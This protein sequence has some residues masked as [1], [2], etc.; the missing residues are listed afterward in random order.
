MYVTGIK[1]YLSKDGKKRIKVFLGEE[2]P[3]GGIEPIGVGTVLDTLPIPDGSYPK[4]CEISI[5]QYNGSFYPVILSI[6]NL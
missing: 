4:G 5:R 3:D 6:Y 2:S 1:K